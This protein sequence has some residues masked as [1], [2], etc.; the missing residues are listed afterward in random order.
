MFV[1]PLPR[2]LDEMKERVVTALST[3]IGD[4]LQRACDDLDYRVPC[5]TRGA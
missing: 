2:N 1:S 3:I 4:K 5:D